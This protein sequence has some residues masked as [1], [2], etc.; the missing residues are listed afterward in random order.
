MS[1]LQRKEPIDIWSM[2]WLFSHN[3]SPSQEPD[4]ISVESPKSR[5][6]P[7]QVAQPQSCHMSPPKN[8]P[9][10]HP[11][12][13]SKCMNPTISTS[14]SWIIMPTHLFRKSRLRDEA[15]SH[16]IGRH[17]NLCRVHVSPTA[18]LCPAAFTKNATPN[19]WTPQ[20]PL[21]ITE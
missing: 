4:K 13:D 12:C 10:I 6:V 16:V 18:D 8:S 21:R 9:K 19:V 15:M 5:I 2:H 14:S 7:Q 11:T 17:D 1:R 3:Y 20:N